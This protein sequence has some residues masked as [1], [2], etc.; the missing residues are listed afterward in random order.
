LYIV[1]FK[2]LTALLTRIQIFWDKT[3][4][5]G[6]DID[7]NVLPPSPERKQSKKL[8]MH[9]PED[10]DVTSSDMSVAIFGT[11]RLGF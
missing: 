8:R 11:T 2:V 4:S 3:P 10:G 5:A 9:P 7:S 6:K 1:R